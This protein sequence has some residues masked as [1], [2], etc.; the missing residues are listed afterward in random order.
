MWDEV[1]LDKGE[2]RL[3]FRVDAE[4]KAT[5]LKTVTAIFFVGAWADMRLWTRLRSDE[6]D[7]IAHFAV[8]NH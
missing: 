5:S 8:S 2:F 7:F 6:R 1:T 4:M 3:Y